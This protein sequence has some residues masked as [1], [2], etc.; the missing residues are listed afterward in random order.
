M[1]DTISPTSDLLLGLNLINQLTETQWHSKSSITGCA[2]TLKIWK[3][4]I[5][6]DAMIIT[7]TSIRLRSI[8]Y[9]FK[10]SLFGLR[11]TRQLKTEKGFLRLKNTGFG[12]RHYTMSVWKSE[13]DLK[14]FSHTGAHHQAMK[15]SR[16]IALEIRTYTFSDERIPPWK[17]VREL[18]SEKGKV[19][20]F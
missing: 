15:Q 13:E 8:W 11:I 3:E 9:F 5:V 16:S 19:L 1:T 17:E 4:I 2:I 10:L 7:V 18:L 12:Y 6:S 20:S 14:R